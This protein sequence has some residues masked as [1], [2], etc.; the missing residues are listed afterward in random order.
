MNSYISNNAGHSHNLVIIFNGIEFENDT[1]PYVAYALEK[2]IRFD[3]LRYFE[4]QD[5]EVYK[6]A[7]SEVSSEYVM[8]LNS[9]SVL[10]AESWL[11]KYVNAYLQSSVGIVGSS[12]S[13]QSY[14]STYRNKFSWNWNKQIPFKEYI[15]NLKLKIKAMVLWRFYFPPFPNPHIRTNAFF[16]NR[17]LFLSLKYNNPI[18]KFH[19][20]TIES[21]KN[22]ITRQTLKKG[23][24]ILIVDKFGETY[25]IMKW[26]SSNIFWIADQENL[27]ISDN[28]TRYYQNSDTTERKYL[29]HIAWGK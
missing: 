11:L 27:L 7:A 9:Y 3:Q 1:E 29:T 15:A 6:K 26:D 13:S 14:Y 22:S 23:L 19:A 5:L 21:G 18:S 20:Y 25:D 16:M 24:R 4:G 28:Q 8:F 17:K 10:L 2:G 12:A